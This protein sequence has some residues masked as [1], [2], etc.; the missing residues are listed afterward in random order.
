VL[1]IETEIEILSSRTVDVD[2][3]RGDAEQRVDELALTDH[4]AFGQPP[5][6]TPFQIK[7]IASYPSIVLHAP[8]AD[9][10]PRLATTRFLMKRWS[11]S[12]MLFK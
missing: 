11:C 4:V 9:R 8:S 7:C 2:E 10:K 3:S 1:Q 12:M 6:L 5:N